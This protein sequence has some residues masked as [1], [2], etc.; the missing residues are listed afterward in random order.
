M[1]SDEY[2]PLCF[3]LSDQDAKNTWQLLNELLV[4]RQFL[5]F[6]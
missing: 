2:L 1:G 5:L 3:I 4:K 6:L